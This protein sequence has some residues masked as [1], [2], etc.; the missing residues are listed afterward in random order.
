MKILGYVFLAILL[1]CITW[2]WVS[3]LITHACNQYWSS[4]EAYRK[5]MDDSVSKVLD[6]LT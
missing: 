6:D 5:R 3:S 1:F 4:R 2:V